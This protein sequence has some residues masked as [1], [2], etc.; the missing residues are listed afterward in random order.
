MKTL[1][2]IFLV[3]AVCAPA[4]MGSIGCGPKIYHDEQET[5]RASTEGGVTVEST[6]ETRIKE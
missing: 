4:F 6:K 2:R 1:K 3:I 5:I